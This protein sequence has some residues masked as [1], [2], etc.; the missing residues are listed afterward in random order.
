MP[1]P[2]RIRPS[3]RVILIDPRE[4]LLLLQCESPDEPGRLFWITPGGGVEPDESAKQAARR[5]LWEEVGDTEARLG[6]VVW[7]RR[8]VFT[9][10]EDRIDQREVYFVARTPVHGVRPAALGA[11]EMHF[12]RRFRWW[13]LAELE[14]P[15]AG[16]VFAPRRLAGFFR[17]LLEDGVP[18]EPIDVGI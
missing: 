16:T 10:N 11:E 9:W 5:E 1:V 3:A 17:G 8:H 14:D 12:I 6:P 4:R 18:G 2:A 15:P 13:S 7:T